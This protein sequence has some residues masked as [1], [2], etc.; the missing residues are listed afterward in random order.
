MKTFMAVFTGNPDGMAKW[1]ALDA[2]TRAAREKQ[3]M[4]AWMKWGETHQASIVDHGGP[5]GKTKRIT[6]GGVVD[7]RNNLAGYT[8]VRAGSHE[9]AANLFAGHP[10][11]TIFP[12]DGVEVMEVLPIPV[13]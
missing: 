7:I 4:A 1:N 11:F 12:G 3:G 8:L 2:D 9:A 10:H 13:E 5:L 6:T